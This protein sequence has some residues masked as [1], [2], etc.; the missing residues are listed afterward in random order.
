MLLG[1]AE[2]RFLI[3]KDQESNGMDSGSSSDADCEASCFKIVLLGNESVG[4][5]ALAHAFCNGVGSH[6]G[7]SGSRAAAAFGGGGSARG[8]CGRTVGVDFFSKRITIP[9]SFRCGSG[10]ASSVVLHLWDV[11]GQQMGSETL[12]DYI[13]DADAVC[14]VYDVTNKNS[15]RDLQLWHSCVI[16]EFQKRQRVAAT[17]SERGESEGTAAS[18][19]SGAPLSLPLSLA[20]TATPAVRTPGASCKAYE[21]AAPT[22]SCDVLLT[23]GGANNNHLTSVLGSVARPSRHLSSLNPPP[24]GRRGQPVMALVAAKTDVAVNTYA[25]SRAE[26]DTFFSENH[27]DESFYVSARTG[28]RVSALFLKL[29]AD[30]LGLE[31]RQR[32]L[33]DFGFATTSIDS[34]AEER[35]ETKRQLE[36]VVSR[37]NSGY[38]VDSVSAKRPEDCTIM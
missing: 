19:K 20:A 28:D 5:S 1:L 8:Q 34:T 18:A 33:D 21:G 3:A 6:S 29:A 16:R 15:F 2:S 17:V 38:G 26:H 4:K 13:F 32:D 30:L 14:L 27:F 35:Q 36:E 9:S 11:G 7:N 22:P 31:V 37:F 10:G 23:G 12:S 24:R 25:V